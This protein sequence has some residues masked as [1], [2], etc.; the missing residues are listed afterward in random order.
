MVGASLVMSKSI[1]SKGK[2]YINH[3]VDA[4][5]VLAAKVYIYL[6]TY[7]VFIALKPS[8]YSLVLYNPSL[9]QMTTNVTIYIYKPVM[10]IYYITSHVFNIS[11]KFLNI[12]HLLC[13]NNII[14]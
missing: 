2:I 4:S 6:I 12:R 8:S 1:D 9:Y 14:I 7:L 10:H 13:E 11:F 5:S 3:M